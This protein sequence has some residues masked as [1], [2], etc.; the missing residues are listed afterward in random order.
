MSKEVVKITKGLASVATEAR[1]NALVEVQ[2]W[3]ENTNFETMDAQ[4]LEIDLLRIWQGIF[5]CRYY[6]YIVCERT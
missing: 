3:I 4:K 5:Y 1:E 2:L 6:I